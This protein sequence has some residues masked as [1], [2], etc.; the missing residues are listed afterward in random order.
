MRLI[1]IIHTFFSTSK[2][3]IDVKKELKI[4]KNQ[5]VFIQKTVFFTPKSTNFANA[6]TIK[7]FPQKP[8]PSS[9][10]APSVA[11]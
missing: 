4:G 11:P 9:K 10:A 1:I 6:V 8:L 7:A 5:L 2:N 3:E